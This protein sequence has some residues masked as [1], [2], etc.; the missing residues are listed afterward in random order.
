MQGLATASG[1]LSPAVALLLKGVCKGMVLANFR[2]LVFVVAGLAA[3]G[4]GTGAL[5]F[6]EPA[7]PG[8]EQPALPP[9]AR[10]PPAPENPRPPQEEKPFTLRTTNFEVHAPTRRVAQLIGAEAERQRKAMALRWLGKEMDAWT[11]RC[12]IKVTL[13]T[14]G[15]A[16][17]RRSLLTTAASSAWTCTS[18]AL[19][20]SCSPIRCRTK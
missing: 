11:T 3:L 1:T 6:L 12:P 20:I 2:V 9:P 7:Q 17:L 10:V 18:R 19:S 4:L 14:N 16:A 5:A 8:R 15:A 13:T